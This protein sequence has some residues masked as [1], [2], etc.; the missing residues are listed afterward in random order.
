[1]VPGV[2]RTWGGKRKTIRETEKALVDKMNLALVQT[3]ANGEDWETAK[4]PES[5]TIEA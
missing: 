4:L 2:K 1:M 3:V 5:L